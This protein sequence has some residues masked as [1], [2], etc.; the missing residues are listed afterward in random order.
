[1]VQK[2]ARLGKDAKDELGNSRIL[3][4][5]ELALSNVVMIIHVVCDEGCSVTSFVRY[6]FETGL[7]DIPRH[8]GL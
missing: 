2:L 8:Y 3:A 5:E 1:M 6:L 4:T 7:L